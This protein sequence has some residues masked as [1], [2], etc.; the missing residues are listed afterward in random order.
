VFTYFTAFTVIK[1]VASAASLC[2]EIACTTGARGVREGGAVLKG[3]RLVCTESEMS[4][5]R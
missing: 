4:V 2:I 5:G 3:G 1:G